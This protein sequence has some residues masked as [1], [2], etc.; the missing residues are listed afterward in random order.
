MMLIT[1]E[2]NYQGKK[3]RPQTISKIPKHAKGI[4]RKL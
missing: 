3:K 1:S 2:Q 4:T